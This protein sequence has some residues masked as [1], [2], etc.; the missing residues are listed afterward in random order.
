MSRKLHFLLGAAALVAWLPAALAFTPLGPW[1]TW[2][3]TR[4]HYQLAGDIGGPMNI[5]EEFR[6]NVPTLYYAF[7][8][9][10][11]SYF[12]QRGVEE[13]EKAIAIL[14]ALPPMSQVDDA[15]LSAFPLEARRLNAR[16]QALS[17]LDIKS[18]TLGTMLEFLGVAE[19]PRYIFALRDVVD[20][21]C[22]NSFT[23]VRRS[24]DPFTLRPS[25]YIN[26]TLYTYTDIFCSCT[27]QDAYVVN[28]P[29]DA[30]AT[31]EPVGNMFGMFS[32]F[33]N[34]QF[35][36]ALTRD[37]VGALRHIYRRNN[38]NYESVV[39]GVFGSG[40]GGSWGIPGTSTNFFITNAVRFG[41]DKIT[42][43][44]TDF[45]SLLGELFNPI[46]NRWTEQVI[47]NGVMRDQQMTRAVL[48]PDFVFSGADL[49]AAATARGV[50]WTNNPVLNGTV[51][52]GPGVIVP[53][54]SSIIY[55]TTGPILVNV[56]GFYTAETNA[57]PVFTWGSFDSSTNITI[58]PFGASVQAIEGMV[59][60]SSS[61]S[62][63]GTWSIPAVTFTIQTGGG[64]VGGGVGGP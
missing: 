42:F 6:Y 16:A 60:G 34:G 18:V 4:K 39:D 32:R 15:A 37:D 52:A 24:F 40:S 14:N 12:G 2:Q 46:T 35:Y 11:L 29:V 58:Y 44:R 49:L 19:S 33:G 13:V 59:L 63:G 64:G 53:G 48:T 9:T 43:V 41:V 23:V 56:S 7:D 47:T 31:T 17:L 50:T 30:L 45:D 1:D 10:F 22:C 3:D 51:T 21:P 27:P 57:I 54:G 25:S 28:A 38:Q 55:N 8:D 26:G 36:T 5:N 62:G 61:G 20:A